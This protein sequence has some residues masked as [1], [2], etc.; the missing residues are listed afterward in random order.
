MKTLL[1]LICIALLMCIAM[2]SASDSG[3]GH[4]NT[5]YANVIQSD[6]PAVDQLSGTVPAVVLTA[7][8][9]PMAYT[10]TADSTVLGDDAAPLCMSPRG[11]NT[12]SLE[13]S[14]AMAYNDALS[15]FMRPNGDGTP[16][17]ESSSAM[18][19]NDANRISPH[20]GCSCLMV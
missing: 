9:S 13:S 18:A 4:G 7:L 1:G 15:L 10:M 5:E 11:A 14:S 6:V 19:Y 12:P 20:I 8:L 3:G 17:L 16:F 2:P